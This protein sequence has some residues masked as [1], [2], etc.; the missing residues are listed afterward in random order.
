MLSYF[1]TIGVIDLAGYAVPTVII[2]NILGTAALFFVAIKEGKRLELS[3]DKTLLVFLVFYIMS[4]FLSRA[5]FIFSRAFLHQDLERQ[6]VIL[7]FFS[8]QRVFFGVLIAV[9]VAIP[10]G[11]YLKKFMGDVRKYYDVFFLGL[12]ACMIITRLGDALAHYH[13][14]KV[15]SVFWG[16]QVAGAYRHEPSLYEFI[17]LILLFLL[18]WNLRR[19]IKT[20]GLLALII[21][22]W[23][24]LSRVITDFFRARDLPFFSQEGGSA[25][26]SSNYYFE[27]GLT[28][29]QLAYFLIFLAASGTLL[30]L[31]FKKREIFFWSPEISLSSRSNV[32]TPGV[33]LKGGHEKE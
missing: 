17:S 23:M 27:S 15:A 19:K 32:E 18:A 25:F 4:S 1:P 31:F 11:A 10:I 6:N 33:E 7:Y 29:N 5:L 16:I 24:S 28:L 22:A 12:A 13:P 26:N 14:G 21:V 9:F 2:T 3:L 8:T 30:Y 20:P